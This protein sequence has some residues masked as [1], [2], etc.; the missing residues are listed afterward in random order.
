MGLP[1]A[2]P[3]WVKQE[4]SRHAGVA[5][6]AE[7]QCS[8]RR[9]RESPDT[10]RLR[11]HHHLADRPRGCRPRKSRAAAGRHQALAAAFHHHVVRDHAAAEPSPARRMAARLF[12]P[13]PAEVRRVAEGEDHLPSPPMA[14]RIAARSGA[15]RKVRGWSYQHRLPDDGSAELLG[16]ALLRP[17]K[18]RRS[19]AQGARGRG[20]GCRRADLPADRPANSPAGERCAKNLGASEEKCP[21]L[22][23]ASSSQTRSK[24]PPPGRGDR[25]RGSAGTRADRPPGLLGEPLHPSELRAPRARGRSPH[26]EDAVQN[27]PTPSMQAGAAPRE[28]RRAGRRHRPRLQQPARRHPRQRARCLETVREGRGEEHAWSAPRAPELRHRRPRLLADRASR[29]R[30]ERRLELSARTAR[31]GGAACRRQLA[32]GS[33]VVLSSTWPSRRWRATRRSCGRWR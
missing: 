23:A 18:M 26:L 8:S 13:A 7:P 32:M 30:A 11:V 19:R 22:T 21:A 25:R 27:R 2:R 33:T 20:N 15:S 16:E 14:T 1:V 31:V 17:P 29:S 12:P 3:Q 28:P 9:R 24:A 5:R 4:E 6:S 10:N